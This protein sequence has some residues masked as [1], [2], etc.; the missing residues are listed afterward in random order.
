MKTIAHVGL[1][2]N[3]DDRRGH[4]GRA[5]AMLREAGGRVTPS[6]YYETRPVG[7]PP[8]QNAY[9]N[10]AAEVETNL[11]AVRFL[12]L[13]QA[14]E[15]QEGRVRREH[16]GERT[17]DLDLLLFGDQVIHTDRLIVPHPRMMLRAFVL[18]PL[19]TIAPEAIEP[20][21][22]KS[23]RELLANCDARPGVIDL[24]GWKIVAPD[25]F[26]DIALVL[27]TA[28]WQ[29][30]DSLAKNESCNPTTTFRV[31]WDQVLK[32]LDAPTTIS[33]DWPPTV[34]VDTSSEK[35]AIMETL[36]TA[37]A[38]RSAGTFVESEPLASTQL[39]Y[40][41]RDEKGGSA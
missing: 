41:S 30:Q 13:L 15:H 25:A 20:R 6:R 9:L 36:T 34:A 29:I 32:E 35:L 2:S 7:G 4:L 27:S 12:D 11:S 14:I 26:A 17:L 18:A 5:V 31:L 8:G 24:P 10:A 37:E 22:G 28:D 16:W 33:R 1:G 19:A 23:V 21:S 40:N 38:T 39:R 3:L